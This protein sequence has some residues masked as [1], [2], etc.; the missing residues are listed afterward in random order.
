VSLRTDVHSA[1][2]EVAPPMAGVSERVVQAV[3]RENSGPQARE[4][5]V[6]LR[7]PM[8][9]VA[10]FVVIAMVAAVLIG[11]RLIQNWNAFHNSAPAGDSYQ[12]QVAQVE[13]VP[14]RI[15]PAAGCKS[16]PYN[17]A[18]SF[19][20]GPVYGDAGPMSTSNW[21]A[22]FHNAAYADTKIA[23]PI[24]IRALDLYTR[25]PVVFIGEY[26]S[27]PVVA[28]DTVAG[29]TYEQHVELLFDTG[30]ASKQATTH[31]FKWPFIAGVPN[32]W[33]GSTGWQ[34]DGIGFSEVFLS[35]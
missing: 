10:V 18:G 27:G 30:S 11:G 28:S 22:Y 34:I 32:G 16:G 2:D 25:Q 19:G 14:L 12:S 6:R 8:S 26:A 7:G 23:G 29:Q 17:A 3:L 24:L 15:P 13:A 4:R 1:F 33:S 35:C 21:G 9:L 5:L 20:S 31:K